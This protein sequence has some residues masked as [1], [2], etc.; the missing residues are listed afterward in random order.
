MSKRNNNGKQTL[1]TP[2]Q[3]T[4]DSEV[5]TGDKS[6]DIDNFSCEWKKKCGILW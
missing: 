2:V 3:A 6:A 5:Y 4:K 1:R